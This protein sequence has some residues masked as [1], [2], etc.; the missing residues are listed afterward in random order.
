MRVYQ[1][2]H[3]RAPRILA[4]THGY[5]HAA[6]QPPSPIGV[7][8]TM[9]R[10]LALLA[11]SPSAASRCLAVCGSAAAAPHAG[12]AAGRER[13]HRHA[14]VTARR[15][16]TGAR[17]PR[18]AG[19]IDARAGA[20][21]RRAPRGDPAAR[22][23]L[24]LPARAQRRRRRRPEPPLG[25]AAGAP[26]RRGGRRRA[27]PTRVGRV[28]AADAARPRGPG[29]RAPEPGRRHQDRRS[30]TTASTRRTRTSHP[31]GTR[32]RRASRRARP[33]T[34]PPR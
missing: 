22:D 27:P 10:V 9:N 1:F 21:R 19:R 5:W 14:R 18:C 33:P 16:P 29:R 20:V 24:A 25:R 13:G 23:P 2:R 30:S 32:C 12:A 4:A 8:P 11:L 7:T 17:R 28:T 34:R 15:G 6:R 31:P 26:G 3:I